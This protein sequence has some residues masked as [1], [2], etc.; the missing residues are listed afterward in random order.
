MAAASVESP[1][2]G[3]ALSSSSS[4]AATILRND[5]PLTQALRD[6]T[7]LELDDIIRLDRGS[8]SAYEA[9]LSL[10]PPTGDVFTT[11]DDSATTQ[12]T[13]LGTRYPTKVYNDKGKG[14]AKASHA[15]SL[16]VAYGSGSEAEAQRQETRKDNLLGMGDWASASLI[17]NEPLR[18]AARAKT[19]RHR[20]RQQKHKKPVVQI[21]QH[22]D[23]PR[24]A[25]DEDRESAITIAPAHDGPDKTYLRRRGTQHDVNQL[26]LAEEGQI[27]T[28]T[29]F[30]QQPSS[31]SLSRTRLYLLAGL[32]LLMILTMALSS[33][34]AHQTG[35]LRIACTKGIVFG[36]TVLM[37]FFI[38]LTMIVA[39]RDAHEAL[40]AGLL[41]VVVGFTLLFEL[42]DF[43]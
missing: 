35:K 1:M 21:I 9:S 31:T 13:S 37:A 41:E 16:S 8:S 7:D 19:R 38:I 43:M 27:P 28:A 42:D 26:R 30:V 32:I 29:A 2:S 10:G 18:G 11:Q 12:P 20:E 5:N 23:A 36:A 6:G 3:Q 17:P 4:A 22:M 33:F 34:G 15:S 25:H 39:R 14:K 40:L 24:I